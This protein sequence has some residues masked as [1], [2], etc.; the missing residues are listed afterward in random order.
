MNYNINDTFVKPTVTA[1]YSDG[2]TADVTNSATF[3]GYD[4]ST[5]GNQTVTVSYGGKTATYQNTVTSLA[6]IENGHYELLSSLTSNSDLVVGDYYMFVGDTYSGNRYYLPASSDSVSSGDF[7]KS[8]AVVES[9]N[10]PTSLSIT[11]SGYKLESIEKLEDVRMIGYITKAEDGKV[12][13]TRDGSVFDLKAQ[14]WNPLKG[15]S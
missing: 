6:A 9:T 11:D 1:T 4:L 10:D 15:E 3:T 14:G 8:G 12:L 13:I 2:H 7:S 5:A